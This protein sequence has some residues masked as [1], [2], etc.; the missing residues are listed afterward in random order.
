MIHAYTPTQTRWVPAVGARN[1]AFE[2]WEEVCRSAVSTPGAARLSAVGEDLDE[3]PDAVVGLGRMAKGPVVVHDV[4]V[5]PTVPDL[6]EI[7]RQDVY[8]GMSWEALTDALDDV[9]GRA[10]SVNLFTH[11]THAGIEQAWRKSRADGAPADLFGA[12]PAT[13]TLH[14]LEGADPQSV[15][16]Q[17]TVPGPWHDRLPHFRMAFTPSRGEEL[18]S[19]Y[20]L[21]RE[22]ARAATEALLPLAEKMAPVLQVSELRTVAAD[23]LW[24]SSSYGHDVL[25]V[26]F[27]WTREVERVTAVLPSIEEV[28]LPLRARPHWGKCFVAGADQLEDLYPRF[29]DFRELRHRVDPERKFGNAFLDRVIG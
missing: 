15:T 12:L 3:L 19:E 21:P 22:Q 20:L 23:G 17:L 24:L 6:G 29:A 7:A 5:A 26:H 10:Y 16:E 11:W 27:T 8:T 25:G 2:P 1:P 14:V 4:A 18:Q 9:M 28:L 13:T